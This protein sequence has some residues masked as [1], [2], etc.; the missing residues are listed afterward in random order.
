MPSKSSSARLRIVASAS[1]K[2]QSISQQIRSCP[3]AL[4]VDD[5][6][7]FLNLAKKTVYAMSSAGR[8]PSIKIGSVLRFDPVDLADWIDG[9]TLAPTRRAA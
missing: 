4:T 6:A 9:R 8:M 7:T 5:V 1:D 3:T 2:P